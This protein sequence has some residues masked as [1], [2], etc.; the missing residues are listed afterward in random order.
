MAGISNTVF[1]NCIYLHMDTNLLIWHWDWGTGV[2]TFSWLV[3][4]VGDVL[5]LS[6]LD[7]RI[8]CIHMESRRQTAG[9]FMGKFEQDRIEIGVSN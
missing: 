1:G 7:V 6:T 4:L 2:W 8:S 5:L 3:D 9:W